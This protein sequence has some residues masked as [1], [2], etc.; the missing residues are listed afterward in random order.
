VADRHLPALENLPADPVAICRLV[1]GLVLHPI[2]A[3]PLGLL[4]NRSA[5]QHLV[6][7]NEILDAL[8]ARVPSPV[9]EARPPADRVIGTCRHFALLACAL[10]RHQ[11]VAARARCGFGMYFQPGKGLDHWIIEYR[12]EDCWVRVDVQHLEFEY[13]PRPDDL[14]DGEFLTGGEAWSAYRK[15]LFKGEQFGVIGTD[16][17]GEHEASA[18][19]L[20]DLAALNKI[21]VL[22]WSEWGQMEDAYEGRTGPDYDALMDRVA[23]VCAADDPAAIVELQVRTGP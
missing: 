7:T 2:V 20:R 3:E 5:E 13:V 4:E 23:E 1:P 11:G 21:E 17:W 14:A 8:L 9:T 12:S 22:P 6:T 10:L 19:A 16:N 15:G 18:N